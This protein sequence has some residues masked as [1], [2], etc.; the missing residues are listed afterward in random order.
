MRDKIIE[1]Y[2]VPWRCVSLVCVVVTCERR[3]DRVRDA[4]AKHHDAVSVRQ[5]VHA[6]QGHQDDGRQRVVGA[7]REPKD[8]AER[9]E[10]R[11]AGGEERDGGG[12]D[13]G[14]RR[15]HDVDVENVHARPVAAEPDGDLADGGGDADDGDEEGGGGD[16][17]G[18]ALPGGVWCVDV[19]HVVRGVQQ[20]VWRA[21]DGERP[22]AEDGDVE[23]LAQHAAQ[24]PQQRGAAATQAALALGR[25]R[26][27]RRR[28]VDVRT[29]HPAG[30][31]RRGQP[32]AVEHVATVERRRD[33][34]DPRRRVASP[35]HRPLLT[36]PARRRRHRDLPERLRRHPRR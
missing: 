11:E 25:R 32:A 23:H 29:A 28:H 12:G 3:P 8:G 7:D 18:P 1:L 33:L 10:G 19:R 14:Q 15:Q 17:H 26:R 13:A 2:H 31:A 6:E 4:L 22:V 20:R 30:G 27:R 9:R 24:R 34:S 35:L 36:R 21:E 5:P 16:G